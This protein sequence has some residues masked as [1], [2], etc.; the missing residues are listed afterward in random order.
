VESALNELWGRSTSRGPGMQWG[1]YSEGILGKVGWGG[2]I[3][4]ERVIFIAG[5]GFE[6]HGKRGGGEGWVQG[7]PP[8]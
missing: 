2:L 5:V 3:N 1:S 6:R 7:W 4:F 8:N